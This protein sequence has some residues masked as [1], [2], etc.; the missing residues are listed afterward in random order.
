MLTK[1]FRSFTRHR[2]KIP[3]AINRGIDDFY[4]KFFI[5]L[6]ACFVSRPDSTETFPSLREAD[7]SV[8]L[9]APQNFAGQGTQWA[10]AI[11]MFQ[12][13]KATNLS[14]LRDNT[15]DYKSGLSV[16]ANIL[17]FG[18]KWQAKFED[19]VTTNITH[20]MLEGAE[21]IFGGRYQ[22]NRTKEYNF[23]VQNKIKVAY[24]FHGTDIRLPSK[25]AKINNYSPFLDTDVYFGRLEK[26]AQENFRVAHV[27][28]AA[29]FVS[30]PDLLDFYPDA[31]WL[32]VVI[33]EQYWKLSGGAVNKVDMPTVVHIPS[34]KR[35]KGTESIQPA[36]SEL[37]EKKIIRLKMLSGLTQSQL[38]K[39]IW[40]SEIVLDQFRIGSYGV[41]ACEA[42]AAG[43]VVIGHVADEVRDYILKHTGFELPIIEATSDSLSSVLQKLLEQPETFS[44][45]GEKGIAFVHHVH[46]GRLSA[47]ILMKKWISLGNTK[48]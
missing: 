32:P 15:V 36:L 42:M 12:N 41:A 29:V 25:H 46:N 31:H 8:L 30:T 5:K 18:K 9:I 39:E 7:E 33:D 2:N 34:N 21:P 24:V 27:N 10:K 3:K 16:E 44:S 1:I 45:I 35:I 26:K 37:K 17:S 11:T 43:K 19:F 23:L 4:D 48:S 14:K 28:D 22:F 40:E 38:R 6:K 47:E 13:L 20:V